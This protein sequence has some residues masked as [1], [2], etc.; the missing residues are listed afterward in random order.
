MLPLNCVQCCILHCV[1]G[2]ILHCV[3][4]CILNCVQCCIH[5]TL[6]PQDLSAYRTA[7][8][9]GCWDRG[10]CDVVICGGGGPRCRRPDESFGCLWHLLS[11][12]LLLLHTSHHSPS[13]PLAYLSS[14]THW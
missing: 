4:G 1:Q 5:T 8:G 6:R 13:S 14:L 11:F 10:R 9:R 12:L 3:Q 7:M 2:C